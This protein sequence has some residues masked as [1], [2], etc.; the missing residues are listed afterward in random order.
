[1]V[2][3]LPM[4]K[5]GTVM[6]SQGVKPQVAQRLR[7]S[8]DVVPVCYMTALNRRCHLHGNA[9]VICGLAAWL[10]LVHDIQGLL[11]GCKYNLGGFSLHVLI[12]KYEA[13]STCHSSTLVIQQNSTWMVVIEPLSSS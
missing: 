4:C 6:E 8:V 3:G 10:A 12:G 1:M 7:G 13:Q 11:N 2:T 5:C 9:N